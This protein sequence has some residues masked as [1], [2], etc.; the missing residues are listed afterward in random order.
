M[1]FPRYAKREIIVARTRVQDEPI[2][3]A[4]H[5]GGSPVASHKAKRI[6]AAFAR[7]TRGGSKK[8]EWGL[9]R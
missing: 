4:L 8:V 9:S 2:F 5:I 1:I 3:R 7:T 6:A